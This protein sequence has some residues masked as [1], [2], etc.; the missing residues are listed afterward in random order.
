MRFNTRRI[1]EST[2]LASVVQ[3]SAASLSMETS[4]KR[5]IKLS[6]TEFELDPFGWGEPRCR[7][8]PVLNVR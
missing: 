8:K 6:S 5:P 2:F 3:A 7:V 1:V 4:S